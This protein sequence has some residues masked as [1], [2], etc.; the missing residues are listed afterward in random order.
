[1][2][3]EKAAVSAF[4]AKA[5]DVDNLSEIFHPGQRQGHIGA[6]RTD[7]RAHLTKQITGEATLALLS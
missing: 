3:A 4:I 7:L 1:M 5:V 6:V 2:G